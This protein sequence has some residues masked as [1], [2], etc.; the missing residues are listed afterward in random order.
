ME[1]DEVR[2]LVVDDVVDSADM[3]ALVL[4][5]DG[6]SVRTVNSG[7]EALRV[8]EQF[9][10]LCVLIDIHMPGL[11]GHELTQRLRAIYGGEIVLVAVTGAGRADDR[12][13]DSFSQFDH[14]LRK[15]VDLSLLKKLLPPVHEAA[16]HQ[17]PLPG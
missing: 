9:S 16:I 11:S 5:M 8:V 14:Y 4:A 15:P 3:L 12:I 2:V 10:P 7:E 6:Y 13:S 1:T 17:A